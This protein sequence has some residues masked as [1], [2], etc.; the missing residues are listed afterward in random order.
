M[1]HPIAP[2]LSEKYSAIDIG[3]DPFARHGQ[4]TKER[5]QRQNRTAVQLAEKALASIVFL[6]MAHVNGQPLGF[7]SGFFVQHD[8]I[9][10]NFHVI[11]GAYSGTARLVDTPATYDIEG[12]TASDVDNDLAILKVSDSNVQPLLLGDSDAV[13]FGDTVYISGNSKESE[14][15]FSDGTISG[16]REIGN[17][18]LLQ[19]TAPISPGGSGG[20]VLN[21]KGEVI[22]LSFV[23][24]EDGQSHDCVI[25]SNYLKA[26]ISKSEA[27]KPLAEEKQSVSAETYFYRGNEKYSMRSY[28]D[29]ITAYSEAIRLQP[30]FANAYVNRGLANEKLGQHES[31][32]MDYSSAIKIDPTLARAYNNRGSAKR[33]LGQYFLA[34]EDLSTAIQLDPRYV[35]AYVNRGNAKNSLGHPNEALEDFNTALAFDPNSAEAYNNRGVAKAALMQLP[36]AIKDFDTSIELNP[37]LA[38]AYYSRGIAKYIIGRQIPQAKSDLLTA[39]KLAKRYNDANLKSNVELALSLLAESTLRLFITYS[40]KDVTAKEQLITYLAVMKREG[41]INIWHD[42]EILPGDTWRDS[43]SKNLAESDILV[44]LVSVNSL[45]SA[46]CNR[47]LAEA[48]NANVRVIPIILER[49]DWLDHQ[50]SD[51]QVLPD[52]GRPINLWENESEGW[53]ST[54]AGIRKVIHQIQTQ[55]ASSSDVSQE[56]VLLELEFERGNFLMG[57]R[58]TEEAIKAYSDVIELNPHY[59]AAYN[60][61]GVVYVDIGEYNRAIKDFNTAIELNPNDFFA[62]NNRGNTYSNIGNINNAIKDFNKA[63]TLKPDYANAYNSRGDAYCKDRDFESAIK[64]FGTAIKLDPD[65]AGAYNGRGAA[66]HEKGN[67]EEAIEDFSAAIKRDSNYVSPYI[68]RGRIYGRKGMIPEAID[69]FTKGIILKPD[70]ADAYYDRGVAYGKKREFD[71]AIMDY[72]KAIQLKPINTEAYC[73]RGSAYFCKGEFDLAIADYTKA[74]ELDPDSGEVYCNRGLVWLVL[75]DWNKARADITSAKRIGLDIVDW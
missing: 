58:K 34:L 38:N 12:I 36:D 11:A 18:T 74:I 44:Y 3:S 71:H 62:Y 40:H 46:N 28:Q 42:N 17:Q 56:E 51:F 14:G 66:Y 59:S 60:N 16:P 4:I 68:N 53:Q 55:A 47:E 20:P 8:Q 25:P 35:K 24:L 54:V 31:A 67:L 41:L 30:D 10:T 27:V 57:L 75:Q 23:T 63:I 9:A 7:G 21:E 70:Y 50:L 22:G 61:R 45:A 32:I 65:F 39:L 48:L 43:I 64:D 26:L 72:T 52:K 1:P 13:Q 6:E 2:L 19:M 73:N 33:K 15:T 29:A 37:E 49:C 5:V 69:D